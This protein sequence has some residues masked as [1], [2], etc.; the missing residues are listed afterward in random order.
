MNIDP[1]S[2]EQETTVRMAEHEIMLSFNGDD[3]AVAF[4]EWWNSKGLTAF[5]KWAEKQ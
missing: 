1:P 2:I 3:D 5:L 4:Y